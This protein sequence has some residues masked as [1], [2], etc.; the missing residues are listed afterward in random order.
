MLEWR[1]NDD[2]VVVCACN[3]PDTIAELAGEKVVPGLFPTPLFLPAPPTLLRV[4]GLVLVL[5][6]KP[7]LLREATTTPL[8]GIRGV[9]IAGVTASPREP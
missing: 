3:G 9:S 6:T 7:S 2:A 8:R 5:D 4:L 1:P